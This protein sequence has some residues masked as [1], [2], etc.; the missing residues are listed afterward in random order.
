MKLFCPCL[1]CSFY[2]LIDEGYFHYSPNEA[3]KLMIKHLKRKHG[4]NDIWEYTERMLVETVEKE[5]PEI[6]NKYYPLFYPK[7]EQ[8]NGEKK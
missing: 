5:A 6:L 1:N 8:Q 7:T 4:M 2:I 3:V